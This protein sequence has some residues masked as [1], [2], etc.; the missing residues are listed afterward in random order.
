MSPRGNYQH[1]EEIFEVPDR[2]T[3]REIM[4]LDGNSLSKITAISEKEEE[5]KGPRQK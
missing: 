1:N 3:I 5:G 4:A 2:K